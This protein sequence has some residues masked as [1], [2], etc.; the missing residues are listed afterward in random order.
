MKSLGKDCHNV[1]ATI[2]VSHK[3][4]PNTAP[5]RGVALATDLRRV[6]LSPYGDLRQ[7]ASPT[8]AVG[9]LSC[10]TLVLLR[11]YIGRTWKWSPHSG[12]SSYT[13]LLKFSPG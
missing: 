12:Y 9:R 2:K 8:P 7:G 13:I 5:L 1:F 11:Y 4:P 10:K 6:P 3:T